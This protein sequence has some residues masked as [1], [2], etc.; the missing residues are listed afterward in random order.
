MLQKWGVTRE[1]FLAT[2]NATFVASVATQIA[3][4]R[5]KNEEKLHYQF[6]LWVLHDSLH[7][8]SM[9]ISPPVFGVR[10]QELSIVD[11]ERKTKPEIFLFKVISDVPWF[12][13]NS[14]VVI[15]F[16]FLCDGSSVPALRP[17]L[18]S[19]SREV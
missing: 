15:S 1:I 9:P 7:I 5:R 19:E 18:S 8:V 4:M 3:R 2:C 6:S 10:F 11:S 17:P 13:G 12:L 14:F 16:A